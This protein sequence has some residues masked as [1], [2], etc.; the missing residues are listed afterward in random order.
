MGA[1]LREARLARGLRLRDV[2]PA[3]GVGVAALH[4][5]ESGSREPAALRL[6]AHARV[7]GVDLRELADRVGA[8][9]RMPRQAA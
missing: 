3:I 7:L 1:V 4:R 2:A 6:L 5:Y 9:G 8:S